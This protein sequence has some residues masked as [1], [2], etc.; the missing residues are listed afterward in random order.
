MPLRRRGRSS[1]IEVEHGKLASQPFPLRQSR[2]KQSLRNSQRS[3]LFVT[4]QPTSRLA[5]W[6]RHASLKYARRHRPLYLIRLGST[7]HQCSRY[8]GPR[9]WKRDVCNTYRTYLNERRH[10]IT[11]LYTLAL[12]QVWKLCVHASQTEIRL[13]AKLSI[14]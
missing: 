7:K 13:I 12:N 1:E 2:S 14:A 6:L 5:F 11:L 8:A 9:L 4:L 10:A 3:P